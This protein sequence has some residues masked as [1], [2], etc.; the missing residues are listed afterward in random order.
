M[1]AIMENKDDPMCY[2][3]IE[4]LRGANQEKDPRPVTWRT[5][6]KVLRH[7]N[8][9]EEANVLEKHFIEISVTAPNSGEYKYVL[10]LLLC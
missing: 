9:Q 2:L 3:L 4:W 5:L 8:V 10:V 1:I 7:A 6:I